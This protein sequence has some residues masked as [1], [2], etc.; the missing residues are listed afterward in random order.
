[1][2][3]VFGAAPGPGAGIRELP[4]DAVQPNPEQPR[5]RFAPRGA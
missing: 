1:M 2:T 4:L 3:E 5:K